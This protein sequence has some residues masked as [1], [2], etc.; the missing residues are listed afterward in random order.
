VLGGAGAK[1]SKLVIARFTTVS[2]AESVQPVID[3]SESCSRNL[4]H[5]ADSFNCAACMF[6]VFVAMN[7]FKVKVDPVQR[8]V[9]APSQL[10]QAVINPLLLWNECPSGSCPTRGNCSQ[11]M[12]EKPRRVHRKYLLSPFRMKRPSRTWTIPNEKVLFLHH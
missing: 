12:V 10:Q 9:H 4:L 6:L 11:L 5:L 3:V 8:S 1:R 2:F 7:I